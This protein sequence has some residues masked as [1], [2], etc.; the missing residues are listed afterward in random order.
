MRITG[1]L[2]AINKDYTMQKDKLTIVANEKL[3][4]ETMQDYFDKTLEIKL[5][6]AK[7]KRSLNANRLCVGTSR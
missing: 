3:D 2:V 5:D 4:T 7:K 6:I 1:K